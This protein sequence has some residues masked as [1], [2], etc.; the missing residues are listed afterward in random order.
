MAHTGLRPKPKIINFTRKRHACYAYVTDAKTTENNA[1]RASF[2]YYVR[3]P[4]G[5]QVTVPT[6]SAVT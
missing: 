2:Y 3:L 4:F 1:R 5:C 6:R